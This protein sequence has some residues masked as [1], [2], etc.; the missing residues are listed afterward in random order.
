MFRIKS[1]K[2]TVTANFRSY[3]RRSS[4]LKTIADVFSSTAI[5]GSVPSPPSTIFAP[6]IIFPNRTQDIFL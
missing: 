1:D 3:V 4:F 2:T 6:L 5:I